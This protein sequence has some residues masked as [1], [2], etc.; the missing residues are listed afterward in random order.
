SLAW[1]VTLLS[2]VCSVTMI[3]RRLV[4]PACIGHLVI[5]IFGIVLDHAHD[6]WFVVGGGR[7]GMEYSVT[8]IICLL[9]VLWAYWPR[10]QE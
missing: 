5:L 3:V 6:G 7:N 2:M 4:V 9:A 8:L 1:F 10:R